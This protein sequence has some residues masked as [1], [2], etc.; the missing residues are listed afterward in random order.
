MVG[1]ILAASCVLANILDPFRTMLGI[2]DHARH[3][4]EGIAELAALG[5]E[6]VPAG[7]PQ[8]NLI[9]L[10]NQPEKSNL[11]SGARTSQFSGFKPFFAG[12]L[13]TGRIGNAPEPW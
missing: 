8:P 5:L 1:F 9:P 10:I 2:L 7:M 12:F 6:Q 4:P 13:A 3:G 11:S